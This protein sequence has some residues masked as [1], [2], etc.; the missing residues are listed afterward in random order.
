MEDQVETASYSLSLFIRII[1]HQ[2]QSFQFLLKIGK[3]NS[4]KR[5][6]GR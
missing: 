3:I 5:L 1:Q 2:K 4:K 6:K